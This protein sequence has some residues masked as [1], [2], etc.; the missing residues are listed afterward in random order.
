[1]KILAFVDTHGNK[2]AINQVLKKVDEVDL[3]ICAGD[4]SEWGSNIKSI[5]S[6]FKK[7][8]KPLLII[9]G[10]H[11]FDEELR[12]ECKSFDNVIYLHKGSYT[13][14]NY[15]FFGY[16]GGGF[17]ERSPEFESASKKFLKTVSNESKII[18]VTHGPPYGTKLD[19]LPGLG[20]RGC[21]SLR[22]FIDKAKPLLHICGHL[23][24]NAGNQQVV[25]RTLVVNPG[26]SG[27]IFK[28]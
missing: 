3:I 28:I 15:S 27:L 6:E 24:E 8:K 9:P 11:E 22:E 17:A 19:S 4:V 14:G 10:N 1:M 23:H 13:L 26:P 2:K 20:H 21:K 18:L 5:L 12:E 7:T 16:G 25:G